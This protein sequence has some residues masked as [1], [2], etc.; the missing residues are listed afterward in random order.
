MKIKT[1]FKNYY[2]R[3]N[4]NVISETDSS[5]EIKLFFGLLAEV[6]LTNDELT[7]DYSI[8]KMNKIGRSVNKNLERNLIVT[9]VA[10]LVIYVVFNFSDF[11]IFNFNIYQIGMFCVAATTYVLWY[12][13]YLIIIEN[14][15]SISNSIFLIYKLDNN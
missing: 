3:N 10:L 8:F 15:K 1:F 2:V 4:Y 14:F 7:I 9:T 13:T 6:N 5:L 11:L 12:F